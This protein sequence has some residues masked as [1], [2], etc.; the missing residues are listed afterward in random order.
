MK[1]R[2]FLRMSATG[3]LVLGVAENSL[4]ASKTPT[5]AEIEGPFYPVLPQQ[6]KDLD[7]TQIQGRSQK[8]NG[9]HIEILGQVIDTGGQVVQE[10][11]V[12]IWQANAAGR[13][14]HPHDSNPAPLDSN[15]QGW[16]I[17]KTDQQGRFRFKTVM[18]GAYPASQGWSRPPHIHFKV[19]KLGYEELVTQMY[20]PDQP[21]N[22]ADLLLQ[23]KSEQEQVQMIASAAGGENEYSWT[24]VMQRV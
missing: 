15:F 13:Y 7:L 9:Q 12:D 24:I 21:L 8:A 10:A 3:A 16:G 17:V 23:R 14:N 18:P 20:F 22:A 2:S 5:P 6:D 4:A 19:S 11:T 1:R